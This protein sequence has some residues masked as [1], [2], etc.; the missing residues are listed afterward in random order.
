MTALLPPL[1]DWPP[2]VGLALRLTIDL[3]FT[4][5]VVLAYAR[6]NASREFVFTYYVFNAITCLLCLLLAQVN[7]Q[8]G[9]GLALFGIF[10]ILRYRT[11]QI[12]VRELTY[13]FVVIGIGVVNGVS[14][15]NTSVLELLFVNGVIVALTAWH[16]I[17]PSAERVGS[18]TM[19][20]DRLHLLTPD[21]RA[22]LVADVGA[23][24]GLQVVRVDVGRVDLL[25][26]CAEITV[27]HHEV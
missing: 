19:L 12:R 13:L 18:T 7:A 25:R 2:L 16:E 8:V 20:Y 14:D 21:N 26:D 15:A 23:R 17:R 27:V 5:L 11:E 9:F 3:A 4:M 22:S 24:T 6:R 10:G 1:V